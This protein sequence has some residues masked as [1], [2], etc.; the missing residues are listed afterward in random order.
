MLSVGIHGL[1]LRLVY[2]YGCYLNA[3]MVTITLTKD[4]LAALNQLSKY[5]RSEVERQDTRIF[6]EVLGHIA[7]DS[8]PKER[9]RTLL[10]VANADAAEAVEIDVKKSELQNFRRTITQVSVEDGW[11]SNR[12]ESVEPEWLEQLQQRSYA[13]DPTKQEIIETSLSDIDGSRSRNQA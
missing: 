1:S 10:T 6:D 3:D 4:D 7:D 8:T 9:F 2:K 13:W 11:D 12:H 5:A